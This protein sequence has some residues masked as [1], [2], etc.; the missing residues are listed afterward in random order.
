MPNKFPHYTEAIALG[1]ERIFADRDAE[2]YLA[3][4]A[5]VPPGIGWLFGADI[6]QDE[7]VN[8]GFEQYFFGHGGLVAPEAVLGF[9]AIGQPSAALLLSKAMEKFGPEYPRDRLDRVSV[10]DDMDE[11]AAIALEEL[12]TLFIKQVKKE[13]GGYKKAADRYAASLA[14]QTQ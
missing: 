13:N 3:S 5:G 4:L 14:A 7:V 8:G 9:E 12:E 1:E 11:E 2:E 6:C 10:L